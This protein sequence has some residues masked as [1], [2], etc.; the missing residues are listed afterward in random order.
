MPP[1]PGWTEGF[2]VHDDVIQWKHSPRYWPFVRGIHRSPVNSPHKAQRRGAL[3]FWY[4]LRLNK[5]LS[6]QWWGWWFE[7]PL[8]PLWRHCN[9]IFWRKW[10]LLYK[11][12][13][14]TVK[15][16][17]QYG[18]LSYAMVILRN[19]NRTALASLIWLKVDG[20]KCS[21]M[22][23]ST[24]LHFHDANTKAWFYLIWDI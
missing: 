11:A 8:R 1:H 23:E 10:T 3:M 15:K 17:R 16:L 21:F 2:L 14:C 12:P 5:R 13:P 22:C 20:K 18:F 9:V 19:T 7:T 6:K 24:T 4:D